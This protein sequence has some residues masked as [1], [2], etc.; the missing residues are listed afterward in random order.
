MVNRAYSRT[1]SC[2]LSF[3]TTT[4]NTKQQI[5]SAKRKTET[6]TTTTTKTWKYLK[7]FILKFSHLF[8]PHSVQSRL[9][10][11]VDTDGIEFDPTVV[12]FAGCVFIGDVGV[13]ERN[14]WVGFEMI[15]ARLKHTMGH[16]LFRFLLLRLYVFFLI[17]CFM[18][19]FLIS[20]S[21]SF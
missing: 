5:P 18:I 10:L 1:L 16:I 6:T 15:A 19:L 12:P 21:L 14:S 17:F 13:C 3:A 8:S 20:K 11:F 4:N 9:A 2:A 7:I